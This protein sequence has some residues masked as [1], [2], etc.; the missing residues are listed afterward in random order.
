MDK[1]TTLPL[2]QKLTTF[3]VCLVAIFIAELLFKQALFNASLQIIFAFQQNLQFGNNPYLLYYCRIIHVLGNA[4]AFLLYLT[5]AFP[6]VSRQTA[7]YLCVCFGL[8]V[9]V[10]CSVKLLFRDARPYMVRQSV[11][12]NMCDTSYGTPNSETLLCTLALTVLFLNHTTPTTS[13]CKTILLSSLATFVWLS[14]FLADIVNGVSSLDQVCFAACLGLVLGCFCEFILKESVTK[15]VSKLMDGEYF[16]QTG[17]HRKL[18]YR[19]GICLF[20]FLVFQ[21]LLSVTV[22]S[23][24]VD[25]IWRYNISLDCNTISGTEATMSFGQ[26]EVATSMLL[27]SVCGAYLGLLIDAKF[28]KGSPTT[29][30]ETSGLKTAARVFLLLFFGGI[31]Y[32]MP[33][34]PIPELVVRVVLFYLL[35]PF[36]AFLCLFA[37]SKLLFEFLSLL[38]QDL[39]QATVRY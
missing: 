27:N 5:L 36:F 24:E 34:L 8:G 28:Y 13:R 19:A 12:P 10:R 17:G 38:N 32:M 20:S 37:Y 21:G 2:S 35:I 29:I 9:F 16:T 33:L 6:I 18:A 39:Y 4:P 7:F 26:I 23:I 14:F 31:L 1:V 11:Y 30:H 22:Y 3:T 25:P 15:H